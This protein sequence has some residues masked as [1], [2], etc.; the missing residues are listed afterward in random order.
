[1]KVLALQK[2][3]NRDGVFVCCDRRMLIPALYVAS[4]AVRQRELGS[5]HYDVLLFASRQDV[6][7]SHIEWMERNGIHYVANLDLAPLKNLSITNPRLSPAAL[8][9]LLVP[10]HLAGRYDRLI[11]L[12]VDVS[13]RNTLAPLFTLDLTSFGIA[14]SPSAE[15]P[16]LIV[17]RGGLAAFEDSC[18]A[19]GMTRPFHYFNSGV[20]L[21]DVEWWNQN[22]LGFR[23]LDFL[24]H[25]QEI[26]PFL[27]ENALNAVLD[28]KFAR[29]SPVWNTRSWTFSVPGVN[30]FVEPVVVH[31]D[32]PVKPWIRFGRMS[33]LLRYRREYREYRDFLSDTPW[34]GWLNEQWSLWDFV[35]NVRFDLESVWRRRRGLKSWL[36]YS[37]SEQRAI[38]QAFDRYCSEASFADVEQGLVVHDKGV[39]RLA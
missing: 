16:E 35:Q 3:K 8:Y 21:I 30:C 34:Q 39:L 20:M 10:Y 33:P 24:F 9:R 18:R 12:D 11:Y 38:E 22:N 28:G 26:C 2:Q 17:G 15:L 29:L 4:A 14:A 1:M 27:D 13:I 25:N 31:Y 5:V 36:W 32:G 6:D 19:L 37:P 7:E 23:A